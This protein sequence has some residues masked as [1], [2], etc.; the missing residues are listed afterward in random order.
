MAWVL[1]SEVSSDYGATV[2]SL[3][4]VTFEQS[5]KSG[6][7]SV[8]QALGQANSAIR[9]IDDEAHA[10]A[11]SRAL[12][13]TEA[14]GVAAHGYADEYAL[15]LH[16]GIPEDE[17]AKRAGAFVRGY[18]RSDSTSIQRRYAYAEAYRLGYVEAAW[19]AEPEQGYTEE[20]QIYAWAAAYADAYARGLSKAR[21]AGWDDPADAAVDYAVL[22][23]YGKVDSGFT[24]RNAYANADAYFRG[25]RYAAERGLTDDAH[26]SYAFDYYLVYFNNKV[27]LSWT[28]ERAHI[29]ALTYADA[30]LAGRE[31]QDAATYA[32]AYEEAYTSQKEQGATDEDAHLYAAAFADAKL[33]S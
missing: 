7:V 9:S 4:D 5:V 8:V 29:Y 10:A 18:K 20:Y 23:A 15:G 28:E 1:W 16:N 22:F 24:N 11:Y 26:D 6:N 30:I 19:R 21:T 17:A 31:K 12:A 25:L 14:S 2:L 32:T 27:R 3:Y 33:G 13:Q